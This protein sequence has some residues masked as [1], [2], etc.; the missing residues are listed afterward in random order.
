M[1]RSAA[2]EE[3]DIARL[4]LNK[5]ECA[6]KF[7]QFVGGRDKPYLVS[8]FQLKISVGN[9]YFVSSEHGGYKKRRLEASAQVDY[10]NP[11]ERRVLFQTHFYHFKIPA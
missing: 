9:I 11:V 7:C 3:H 8:A 6:H 1:R 2:A 4:T 10:P 5:P